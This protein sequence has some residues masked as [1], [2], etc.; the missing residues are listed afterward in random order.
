MTTDDQIDLDPHYQR[1]FV[2]S[3]AKQR[4]LIDSIMKQYIVPPFII[5]IPSKNSDVKSKECIDGQH[6]LKVIKAFIEGKP[7]TDD[8]ITWSIRKGPNKYECVHYD[9]APAKSSHRNMTKEE[10]SQFNDYQ[11][12]CYEVQCSDDRQVR[13]VFDRLQCGQQIASIEKFKNIDHPVITL[14]AKTGFFKEEFIREKRFY[15]TFNILTSSASR[16]ARRS[17]L[18]YFVIRLVYM[19]LNKKLHYFNPNHDT[20]LKKLFVE[21][22]HRIEIEE[23]KHVMSA[24]EKMLEF[25]AKCVESKIKHIDRSLFQIGLFAYYQEHP[26]EK[27]IGFI[28]DNA[29]KYNKDYILNS[30]KLIDISTTE[31]IYG[32]LIKFVSSS[33]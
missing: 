32:R 20:N 25:T 18:V 17:A 5:R 33:E 14:L 1:E 9:N 4:L 31:K 16:T 13:E 24:V 8:V 12:I 19:L 15:R 26:V 22:N 7:I 2:W 6:R 11:L 27:I 21:G 30:G 29:K 28:R 10:K 23:G 3:M